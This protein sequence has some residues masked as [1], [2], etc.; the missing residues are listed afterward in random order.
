MLVCFESLLPWSHFTW[1]VLWRRLPVQNNWCSSREDQQDLLVSGGRQSAF[2]VHIRWCVVRQARRSLASMW[3]KRKLRYPGCWQTWW[4]CGSGAVTETGPLSRA[5]GDQGKGWDLV[6]ARWLLVSMQTRWPVD[7]SPAPLVDG[8]GTAV[9]NDFL[10]WELF[11]V[12]YYYWLWVWLLLL[13]L[14]LLML[15]IYMH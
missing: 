15:L 9:W 2:L 4:L 10:Y 6:N 7:Y 14:V 11:Y 13:F 3:L 12:C 8:W 5:G 1:F